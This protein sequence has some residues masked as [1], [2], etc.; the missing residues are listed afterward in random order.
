MSESVINIAIVDDH[1]I[2]IDG[3][4]AL[5]K[6]H[7]NINIVV[8]TTS[9]VQMLQLLSQNEVDVL[10]T[11]VM[12]PQM[13]GCELSKKVKTTYPNIKILVLSMNGEGSLVNELLNEADIKGYVM[14]N[15]GKEHL[16]E[17]IEKNSQ[18]WDVL[19]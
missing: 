13:D 15:I 4:M 16:I 2:V 5:L 7:S 12:M 6:G 17:A 10:L 1:Q 9:S 14:K 11:D 3:I 8:T 19:Y 18:W